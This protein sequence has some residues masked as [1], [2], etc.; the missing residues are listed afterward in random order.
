MDGETGDAVG[1]AGDSRFEHGRSGD[2]IGNWGCVPG[3]REARPGKMGQGARAVRL[4]S[5]VFLPG[6]I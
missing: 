5:L 2:E 4:G 1:G 6:S 3:A